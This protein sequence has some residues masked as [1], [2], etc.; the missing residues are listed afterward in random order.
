MR[1]IFFKPSTSP[2]AGTPSS[3]PQRVTF[4]DSLMDEN[5]QIARSL[6]TKWDD[7]SQSCSISSLFSSDNRQDAKDY[8]KAV[9]DL[10]T[11]MHYF[12]THHSTSD[13]LV[14]VQTLMQTAMKRLEREFYQM[15]KINGEY[16]DHESVSV[17]SS[18]ASRA[19]FSD[20]EDYEVSETESRI[21]DDAISEMERVSTAAMADL[22]AIAD[23]MISAGY[24]K[25]CARIYK[26]IRKSVV[27]EALY[28]LGVERL[29]LNV[30]QKMDWDVLEIKIKNWLRAVRTAVKTV[31]AGERILCDTVFSGPSSASIRVSCFSQI[32]KEGALDLLVFPE[33]VAKCK[34]TPEKM[35]RT[36][37]L[38]E[39][40][41]D[42]S[43]DIASIFSFESTSA[44]RSQAANSLI[45]LGEAVRTMLADFEAA[46]HKDTSKTPVPGGGVHPL[47][48]YVM[49][50]IAFLA[51]YSG[52]LAEIDAEWPLTSNSPL[53][54]AYFGSPESSDSISSPIAV[55]LAWLILVV[56]CKLDGKAELY[57][58]VAQ[59]Y[60][61]LANNLQYVVVK[62]RSSNLKFLL[63]EE[64][65]VKHEAKV[66]QYAANYERMGWDK[67]FASL[68]ENPTAEIP[69]PQVRNCFRRFN[70]SF[71][72]TCKRHSSWIVS[73]PKLRDE[74]KISLAKRIAPVYRDFYEKYRVRVLRDP[75]TGNEPLVRFAPDDLG[76]HLSDLFHGTIGS[77]S[78]SSHSTA[79]YSRT[80]GSASVS[81]HST[82]PYSSHGGRS[83]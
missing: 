63:G 39:A 14:L 32:V 80:S 56:L 28:H 36:L 13:K 77:G 24:G 17:S 75:S 54:E 42:L 23:C 82:S 18:R 49:N 81:S 4:S 1:T 31:F 12:I 60:L 43:P 5:I 83:P 29:N 15:L 51:D 34:K 16:L 8:L 6:I 25:E 70:L 73:D 2:T 69:I 76:N 33:N 55:R 47:T 59:S 58:E 71:E 52:S 26:I 7:T 10:Q 48:R 22:K 11:A 68:P 65:I 20:L 57:K 3:S 9:Y 27:D 67:V 37:D 21:S 30:I 40:I 19:S 46:I 62:V 66:R 64:W 38:Y 61:F 74:I 78:V 53:P 45:R 50:Y 79:P 35:F 44:V 41:S 72:D